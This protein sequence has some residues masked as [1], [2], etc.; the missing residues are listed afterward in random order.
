MDY[1]LNYTQE[2][3]SVSLFQTLHFGLLAINLQA[4]LIQ[5]KNLIILFYWIITIIITIIRICLL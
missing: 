2:Y 3:S 1:Q 5:S 4:A